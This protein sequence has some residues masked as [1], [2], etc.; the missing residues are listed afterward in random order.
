MSTTDSLEL[1]IILADIRRLY[2]K[3]VILVKIGTIALSVDRNHLFLLYD[4][5]NLENF[6]KDKYLKNNIYKKTSEIFYLKTP[7]KH[8]IFKCF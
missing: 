8:E 2:F 7:K 4:R 1:K 5:K 3:S 6:I